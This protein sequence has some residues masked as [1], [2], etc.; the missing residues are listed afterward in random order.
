MTVANLTKGIHISII[1]DGNDS[2]VF[3]LHEGQ[4]TKISGLNGK[5]HLLRSFHIAHALFHLLEGDRKTA[6][7]FN[8]DQLLEL[9]REHEHKDSIRRRINKALINFESN[10]A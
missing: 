10:K 7:V 5:K 4:F 9:L 6:G 1:N 2:T 8:D 3:L